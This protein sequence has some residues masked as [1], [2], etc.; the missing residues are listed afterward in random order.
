MNPRQVELNGKLRGYNSDVQNEYFI[1]PF[2][3][4]KL[5]FH[6]LA[7]SNGSAIL[8][9]MWNLMGGGKVVIDNII[10]HHVRGYVVQKLEKINHEIFGRPPIITS[11]IPIY[12]K[13][14]FKIYSKE[15]TF[16]QHEFNLRNGNSNS[17]LKIHVIPYVPKHYFTATETTFFCTYVT[18]NHYIHCCKQ[19]DLDVMNL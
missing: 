14:N 3:L 8:K 9:I 2:F 6:W 15:R 10:F 1:S 18:H 11:L 17:I 12:S 13:R 5:F 19:Y 4:F 16:K 7:G